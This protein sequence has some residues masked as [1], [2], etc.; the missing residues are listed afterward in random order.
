MDSIADLVLTSICPMGISLM[1][2]RG[3]D[4]LL[5]YAVKEIMP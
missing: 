5:E 2:W 1:Y 4:R 3:M